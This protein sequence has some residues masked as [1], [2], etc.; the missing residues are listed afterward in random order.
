MPVTDLTQPCG[1]LAIDKAPGWTSFDVV[2]KLRRLYG[3]KKIGHTGTLDPA[4]EGLLLVCVGKAT[5]FIRFFERDFKT[6][7]ATLCFGIETDTYDTTGQ[8]T[9][10]GEPDFTRADLD[11]AL[12]GFTGHIMQKPP[13]YSALK[14]NGK[15]YYEYAREGLTIDIPERPVQITKLAI[16]DDTDFPSS[17]RL[18]VTCSAG[19]YIRSLCHDIGRSLGSHAAMGALKRLSVGNVSLDG[20]P[21]IEAIEALS[22]SDRLALLTKVDDFLSYPKIFAKPAGDRFIDNGG[23][24][25][26]RNTDCAISDL[27]DDTLVCLYRSDRRFLGVGKKITEDGQAAIKPVRL[28]I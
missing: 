19:T 3:V 23:M 11:R 10:R 17:V 1:V 5:R 13:I 24:L 28:L 22:Y 16:T 9:S 21:S 6:Y 12:T 14:K 7:E 15:K 4:A 18:I 8:I 2:A 20:A 25:Y 27:S 26:S